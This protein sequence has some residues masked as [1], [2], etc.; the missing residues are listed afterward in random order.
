[1]IHLQS[2]PSQ[3]E[4]FPQTVGKG[5]SSPKSGFVF[6]NLTLSVE[7]IIILAIAFVMATV[8]SFSLGVERGKGMVNSQGNTM[9]SL[10]VGKVENSR[11]EAIFRKATPAEQ[12]PMVT[13]VTVVDRGTA[14]VAAKVIDPQPTDMR[15]SFTVQV[16]SY[17]QQKYAEKEAATLKRIGHEIF[18][19]SKGNYSI[20]CV[21]KFS[22]PRD[23]QKL[24]SQMRNKYKDCLVRRF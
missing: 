18:V 23:A 5:Q 10:P 12:R 16:A 24:L 7:N 9:K 14:L 1:M 4:L 8:L 21:G 17:K 2:K 22:T 6:S 3:L 15:S 20:V 11:R 13:E 19:M